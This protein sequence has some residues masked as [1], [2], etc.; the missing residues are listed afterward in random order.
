M[1]RFVVPVVLV[2]AA[3]LGACGSSD[4]NNSIAPPGTTAAT[5]GATGGGGAT[6]TTVGA[7]TTIK[8]GSS[9]ASFADVC[10][11]RASAI[12]PSQGQSIDY[13]KAAKD[14]QF[15]LDHAPSDIKPDLTILAGPLVQYF[16]ILASS[17]GNF[18]TAASNAQFLTLAQRFS[19][20]DY[21]AAAQRVQAWFASHCS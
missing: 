2:I 3:L 16:Q 15:A 1:R 21:Q 18:A 4:S 12:P 19:Q 13:A 11:G 5:S 17:N 6:A 20:A 14:L 9:N 7:A 8:A 10:S